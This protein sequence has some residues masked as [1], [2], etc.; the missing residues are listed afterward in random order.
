[1][2]RWL[3]VQV[4]LW[5]GGFVYRWSYGQVALSRGGLYSRFHTLIHFI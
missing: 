3:C 2:D 5:T 4:V 1:M